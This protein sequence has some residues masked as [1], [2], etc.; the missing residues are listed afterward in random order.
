MAYAR[1]DL[2]FNGWGLDART[3]EMHGREE[4]L[5]DFVGE[6]LGGPLPYTPAAP[7]ETMELPESRLDAAALAELAKLAPTHTDKRERAFHAVGKSYYDMVRIRSGT[8]TVAPDAVVYPGSHDD[9][10]TVLAWAAKRGIAVVPFGG[11]S[12]VVGGVEARGASDATPVVTLDT[13]RMRRLLALDDLSHTA[14]FETGI[15]GPELEEVLEKRGYTL[16]HF[17]QSFEFSTLGGWIAARGSGQQSNRYG[18][19]AKMLVGAR[20]A[21]PTGEM[22]TS[23]FPNSAAGPDLNQLI[24]GSEGILGV[25]TEA[26]MKIRPIA[27]ARDFVSFLFRDFEEGTAAVRAMTQRGVDVSTLRLSDVDET[28]FYGELRHVLRP[29]GAQRWALKA[30][31]SAGFEKPC[32]LMVGFEGG[33]AHVKRSWRRALAIAT[34]HRGLYV[35]RGPGRAWYQQ[36]FAM[37]YLRDPLMDRGIGIDTLETSTWWS[38][39]PT[40]YAAVTSAIRGALADWGSPGI[41]LAHLSHTY[42]TGTS[43]YFTFLFRRDADDPVGQWKSAKEAASRAISEHGGTISHHH[44]VGT[45]HV[46]WLAA[47]KG[48]LGMAVL[49]AAKARVDPMR[50]MNPG[51][52][53]PGASLDGA[54]G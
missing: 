26:T 7:L 44:G 51:K 54:R 48:A 41:V 49:D 31:G 38:N 12:S 45:D 27:E 6:A 52:I 1:E 37:P 8:L 22:R 40:L 24:A 2:R 3:F 30:L 36:R 28:H 4:A 19:A 34:S 10:M 11:G 23:P 39:V 35:G 5:F 18:A 17:P 33:S 16:G 14:T 25:I 43:L 20:V 13:T 32:V 9:V 29:S 47:E 21:T 42:P 53:L 46:P 15:Y 50:V